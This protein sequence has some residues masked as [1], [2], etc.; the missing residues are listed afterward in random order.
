MQLFA[1]LMNEMNA[2]SSIVELHILASI[3]L[4]VIRYYLVI[5][6]VWWAEGEINDWHAEFVVVKR[7]Y[8]KGN[9]F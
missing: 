2:T 6:D 8:L 7:Y 3:F 9:S 5:F 4:A 1:N